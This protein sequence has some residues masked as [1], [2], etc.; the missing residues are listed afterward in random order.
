MPRKSAESLRVVPVTALPSRL[1]PPE[2]FPLAESAFWKAVVATKPVDWFDDDSA[3]LLARM[4]ADGMDTSHDKTWA[5]LVD[6][7]L[8]HYVE[9]TL[10]APTFLTDYPVELSPLARRKP[11]ADGLVERFE[12]F[13]GGMEISN[14]FSELNDPDDQRARFEE[15]AAAGRAGDEEAH[16]VDEDYLTA[17]EYG[18][19]PTGG[20]GLGID[21]LAMLLTGQDTI[22][23]VVLF[24][25]MRT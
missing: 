10:I 23:E 15:Q 7:M 20:V 2:D 25:A 22:R 4:Q 13:C 24:P 11:G 3:P 14:G 1:D 17:L 5:Q 16:P 9:P 19:P 18:L 6:H 21:R 8:S 12:A